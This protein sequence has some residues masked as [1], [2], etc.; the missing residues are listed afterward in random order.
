MKKTLSLVLTLLLIVSLSSTVLAATA[1]SIS[2]DP[3]G[4]L[5]YTSYPQTYAVTGTATF[6]S[7]L[8][9]LQLKI[10]GVK[11][12]DDLGTITAANSPYSFS[13]DW[14]IL[15]PG[16][17]TVTVTGRHGNDWGSD[18]E[19]VEVIGETVVTVDYPAAPAVA[20]R[21]I[22]NHYP[23]LPRK[24]V[25]FM[26]SEVAHEMGNEFGRGTDF[27]GVAKEDAV[28]YEA[29]VKAFMLTLISHP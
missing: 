17:Y 15:A 10:D 23:K 3:I 28:A 14:H 13:F 18:S 12:G 1:P 8:Q 5:N 20:N 27:H 24:Q 6:E 29:A 25:N 21:I 9:N 16:T 22:R 2:L 19:E 7:P 11:H 4:T 26:I